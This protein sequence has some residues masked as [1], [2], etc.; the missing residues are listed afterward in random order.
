[1]CWD[2]QDRG[3][4]KLERQQE[5]AAILADLEA[6]ARQ[7]LEMAGAAPRELRAERSKVPP[8]IKRAMPVDAMRAIL[9]GEIPTGGFGIGGRVQG[10]K[11]CAIVSALKLGAQAFAR[12]EAP[13]KGNRAVYGQ[14]LAF[15]NWPDEVTAIRRA[16]TDPKTAERLD[17]LAAV[18]LLVLDDLGKE[19][20]KG[21][22]TEDWAASQLDGII[23]A[24]Y[25]HERPTLWTTNVPEA[26]LAAIYGAALLA[27]LT[28][29]NPL[30]W[31]DGL[32]DMRR[33]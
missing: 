12:R 4:M 21:S 22:Y 32:T 23:S 28:A 10:G 31:V 13:T 14:A 6:Y 15:V 3:R 17:H 29:D 1:M 26:E 19:R 25:R 7:Q 11:T 20:I 9:A 24:R 2:C 8:Q 18:P 5:G 16:A 33:A 27:R 30:T